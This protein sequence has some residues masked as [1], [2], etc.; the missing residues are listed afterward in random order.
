MFVADQCIKLKNIEYIL[1]LTKV[2]F[3]G[4]VTMLYATRSL[5]PMVEL[6]KQQKGQQMGVC[7][8]N[9]LTEREEPDFLD[10][11]VTRNEM[12]THHTIT[13]GKRNSMIRKHPGSPV[14]KN[15]KA[16]ST[17]KVMATVF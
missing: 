14:T 4:L 13:D 10:S 9:L 8:N 16:T 11:T 7:L 12:W 17:H 3:I 15:V 6:T 2:L 1:N 5:C